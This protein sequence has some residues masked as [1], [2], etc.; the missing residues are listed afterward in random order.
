MLKPPWKNKL[1]EIRQHKIQPGEHIRV[2]VPVDRLPTGTEITIPVYVFNS[3]EPGPTV[4]LQACAHGDEVNGTETLR[5][6]LCEKIFQVKRGCVIVLPILN[7]FGF[8]NHSREIHGKDVNRCYPG[9]KKGSLARRIAYHHINEIARNVDC[10]IDLHAGGEQR[11]NHPQIRFSAASKP[12]HQ[13]ARIFAAPFY[14]PS[15]PIIGSFRQQALK[16]G[17]PVV[18]FEGGESLRLDEGAISTAYQGIINILNHLDMLEKK[19]IKI[20]ATETIELSKRRWVRASTAGLFSSHI[21]NGAA[22]TKG[23]VLGTI[24]DAYGESII[25]VKSPVD[26]FIVSINH[27]PMINSGDAIFSIGSL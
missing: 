2:E 3:S 21:T 17:I 6:M 18:V 12:S 24:G 14:F 20:T 5:R 25:H 19:T 10:V 13:L 7:I 4:L 9:A 27:F 16:L 23:Q 1:I 26:G 8:L 11:N 15:K 22:V